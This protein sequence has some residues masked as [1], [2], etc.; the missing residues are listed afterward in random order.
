MHKSN[1]ENKQTPNDVCALLSLCD[2]LSIARSHA[3]SFS[4]HF[5][6]YFHLFRAATLSYSIL[7]CFYIIQCIE[8]TACMALTHV[9]AFVVL[10]CAVL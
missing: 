8:H 9:F 6:R 2:S 1:T 5:S 3:L 10:C 4:L 7:F